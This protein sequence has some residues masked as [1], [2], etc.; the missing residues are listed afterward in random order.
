MPDEISE[1]GLGDV[2]GQIRWRFMEEDQSR[3]ELF[4]YF[5]TVFPFQKD[6]QIIGTQ[7]WE[8]K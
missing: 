2:E 6:K 5:E 1:S 7:D 3:P 4:T 8:F